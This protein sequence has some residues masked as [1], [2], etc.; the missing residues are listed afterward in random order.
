MSTS[1]FVLL[2]V[3]SSSD[4][5]HKWWAKV[6]FMCRGE[7]TNPLRIEAETR[8]CF[9]FPSIFNLCFIVHFVLVFSSS[10]DL[11]WC[12]VAHSSF[13]FVPPCELATL[14]S[15][16]RKFISLFCVFFRT[17]FFSLLFVDDASQWSSYSRFYFFF[18]CGAVRTLRRSESS[19]CCRYLSF[20]QTPVTA[21]MTVCALCKTIAV[22]RSR[23]F[24][25]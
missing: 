17:V 15:E 20:C 18:S 24:Y 2:V 23:G 10:S 13:L 1:N 22:A 19:L 3:F 12:R 21:I 14:S 5:K 16:L 25:W 4:Q 9:F 7:E 11:T 8:K 6:K